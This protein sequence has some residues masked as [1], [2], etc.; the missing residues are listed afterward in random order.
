MTT[1]IWEKNKLY[2]GVS[3][4]EDGDLVI[5]G[6]D[7]NGWAGRDEYEYWIT[8][9]AA[10]FPTLRAALPGP[11]DA[12]LLELLKL[13]AATLIKTGERTFVDYLGIEAGF[14][15]WP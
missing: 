15:C 9:K 12:E 11:A 3:Y 14:Y 13:N 7:L 8:V 10:D 1:M 2:V 5:A 6:Q 4:N